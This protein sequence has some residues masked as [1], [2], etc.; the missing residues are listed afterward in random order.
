M[1]YWVSLSTGVII[2]EAENVEDLAFRLRDLG[3]RGTVHVFPMP[4][5]ISAE[6][7]AWLK[8]VPR[9]TLIDPTSIPPDL[10][11]TINTGTYARQA[12]K[13]SMN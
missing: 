11:V 1:I 2:A 13:A 10:C 9:D 3:H 12:A 4:P 7:E 5:A 8:T 6:M